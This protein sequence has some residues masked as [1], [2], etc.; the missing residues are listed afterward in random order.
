MN[1]TERVIREQFSFW[2]QAPSS[3]GAAGRRG[4]LRHRGL[5]HLLLPRPDRGGGLQ[6]LGPAGPGGAGRRMGAAAAR[7]PGRRRRHDRR[8]PVA[9]RRV[10][11]DRAGR[12]GQPRRGADRPS[13]SP[14]SLSSSIVRAAE[15]S[16]VARTHPD[17][18]IVMTSSASLMLIV[19]L[20][21][22]G[23]AVDARQAAVA[24]AAALDRVDAGLSRLLEGRSHFVYLG[25]GA[26]HGLAQEGALKLQ[27]MSLS[28]S[29]AF[30]TMEYR[31][32]PIS[33]VDAKTFAR[34]ALQSRH[35]G[36]GG[37][38]DIGAA[39]QGRRRGGV[40]RSRRSRDRA[41]RCDRGPG[42]RGA[43]GAAD[44]RRARRRAPRP[45]YCRAPPSQ[46]G[47]RAGEAR[48][49]VQLGGPPPRS[50]RCTVLAIDPPPPAEE[51]TMRSM[52]EEADRVRP[53]R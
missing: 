44:P 31:H 36:R 11:R 39:R 6:P 40:R 24:A 42:A 37:E 7:L 20:R 1:I 53:I 52:V 23:V 47:R 50:E 14:A 48:P 4:Q 33:L 49:V 3:T 5:R 43:A 41:R 27:E 18:G 29:Q 32:G 28:Y 51:G 2:E 22:A 26:L 35:A 16:I 21:L 12:R 17:E 10:E 25:A 19:G 15:T 8:R 45:R 46:Q 13:R 34:A 30:H 9:Q 38:A